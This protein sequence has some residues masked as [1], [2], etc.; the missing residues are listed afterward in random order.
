MLTLKLY[1]TMLL[2]GGLSWNQ[3]TAQ[4][5][6]GSYQLPILE[7]SLPSVYQL[8]GT[9]WRYEDDELA[10]IITFDEQGKLVTTHP[11]DVTPQNDNWEQENAKLIFSYNNSFSVYEGTIVSESLII[12]TAHNGEHNWKWRA[13]RVDMQ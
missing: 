13:Y 9:V 5:N 2:L 3:P 8:M 4:L 10:Y 11:F 12:G 7:S 6:D 1:T